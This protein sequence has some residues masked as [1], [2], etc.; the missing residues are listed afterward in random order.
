MVED[1]H[2]TTLLRR[3]SIPSAVIVPTKLNKSNGNHHNRSPPPPPSFS[4]VD[5][6]LLPFK[7]PGLD[8]YTSLKDILPCSPSSILSPTPAV[9]LAGISSSSV[10]SGYEISIRNRL[11]KQAAWAYLQPT[12]SS[13]PSSSS[14][15]LLFSGEY[16]RPMIVNFRRTVFETAARAYDWLVDALWLILCR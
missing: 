1:N 2:H 11:V 9:A 13:S 10:G 14:R 15:R 5:F 7:S 4:A 12:V 8:A 3:N 6:E 16:I